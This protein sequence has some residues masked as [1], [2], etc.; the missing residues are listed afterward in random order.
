MFAGLSLDGS[1]ARTGGGLYGCWFQGPQVPGPHVS[2]VM[3]LN[4]LWVPVIGQVPGPHA[5][6]SDRSGTW[7]SCEYQ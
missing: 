5:S 2:L 6:T 7:T 4:L 3:Y 1:T